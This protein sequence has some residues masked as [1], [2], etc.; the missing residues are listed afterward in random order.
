MTTGLKVAGVLL[1]IIVFMVI[2]SLAL[3]LISAPSDAAVWVGIL[4]L[5]SLVIVVVWAIGKVAKYLK[6]VT[7]ESEEN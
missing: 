1:A 5:L 3:R 6:K 2:L 7:K 4:I